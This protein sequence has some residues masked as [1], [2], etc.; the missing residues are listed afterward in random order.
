MAFVGCGGE[1]APIESTA[2][3]PTSAT[4]QPAAAPGAG[5]E[6][7]EGDGAELWLPES[8]VGGSPSENASAVEEVAGLG[9]A[10]REA[11]RIVEQNPSMF[12]IWAVDGEVGSSGVLTSATVTRQDVPSSVTM[13]AYLGTAEGQ[14]PD[15]WQMPERGVVTLGDAEAG[16]LVLEPPPLAASGNKVKQLLYFIRDGEAMWSITYHAGADEWPERLPVFEQSALTFKTP[17]AANEPSPASSDAATPGATEE[18]ATVGDTLDLETIEGAVV[19]VTPKAT[20]RLPRLESYGVPM[21][22][23][24]FGVRITLENVGDSVYKDIVEACATL[25]D[26]KGRVH[27]AVVPPILDKDAKPM[28]GV[29]SDVKLA[30]GDT[31]SGWIYFAIGN[32]TQPSQFRF[33]PDYGAGTQTGEWRVD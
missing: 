11:T 7:Y 14:L 10:F 23:A 5:W 25:V 8:F 3:M 9:A 22:P 15:G 29:L 30:P 28:P 1:A 12:A 19:A 32:A 27:K 13:E 26:A 24:L 18:A 16:R 31:R 21:H 20:K 6:K 2:G 33:T 4:T 17:G